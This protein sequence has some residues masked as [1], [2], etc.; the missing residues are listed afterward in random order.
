MGDTT[1]EYRVRNKI[2]KQFTIDLAKEFSR[3]PFGRYR[4]DGEKSSEA[5]RDD[6]LI[7][8][9]ESYDLVIVNLGGTNY[10]GSTFLEETFGGLVRKGFTKDELEK[11]LEVMH[12]NLPSIQEEAWMY[13]KIESKEINPSEL[14]EL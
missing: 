10:Y 8:N 4:K 12:E 11:K 7:P 1:S 2:M 3:F 9:L 5:F 6:I 14:L 13:I